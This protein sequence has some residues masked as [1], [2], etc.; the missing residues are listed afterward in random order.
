MSIRAGA[1]VVP[2]VTSYT[3][4]VRNPLVPLALSRAFPVGPSFPRGFPGEL[5]AA[6]GAAYVF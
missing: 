5:A 1:V 3:L 6:D 4:A 2:S